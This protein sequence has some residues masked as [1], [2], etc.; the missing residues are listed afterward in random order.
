MAI[1]ALPQQKERSLIFNKNVSLESIGELSRLILDINQDDEYISE[2]Y[3]LHGLKYTP[4]PIKIH[5]DS[6]GGAVYQC[7]GILGIIENSKTPVHTIVTGCAMSAAF[8]M[9]ISGHKRYA[10]SG[11]TFM[12][13]QLS[14]MDYG[15]LKDLDDGVIEGKRLQQMIE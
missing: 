14:N 8:L 2:I 3:N 5:I 1:I 7:L 15:K 11:A 13:H 10:Y 4:K 9:S 6:Y 12:Y